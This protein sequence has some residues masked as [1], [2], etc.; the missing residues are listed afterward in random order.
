MIVACTDALKSYRDAEEKSSSDYGSRHTILVLD[1]QLH[2]IPWESLPCLDGQSVSRVS[3]LYDLIER[4]SQMRSQRID[5]SLTSMG[6]SGIVASPVAGTCFLNPSGD[7]SKTQIFHTVLAWNNRYALPFLSTKPAS[8]QSSQ[9]RRS[10]LF[11]LPKITSLPDDW[12]Q[13]THSIKSGITIS[14]TRFN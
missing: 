4:L 11:M 1:K 7:L 13:L 5:S 12:P 2:A 9:A 10:T 6:L 8:C 3:S 14:Q